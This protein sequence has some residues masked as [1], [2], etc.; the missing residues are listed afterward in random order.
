MNTL[1]K[2]KTN[3]SLEQAKQDLIENMK[4]IGFGVLYQLNFKDKVHEKGYEIDNNFIMM[5]VC[6]PAT[7]S[8][9]LKENIEMGYVLPC[10]VV[11]YENGDERFI[12]LMKPTV[13]VELINANYM[14]QAREIEADI[15]LIIEKSV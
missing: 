3:K 11:V 6:N 12:G 2:L 15:K 4:D 10:K 14:N 8:E 5:D 1:Y 7:A 13:M 9:I